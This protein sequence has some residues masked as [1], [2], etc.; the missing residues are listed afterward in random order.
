MQVDKVIGCAEFWE[1]DVSH[2]PV[3]LG[4]S[5]FRTRPISLGF[6]DEVLG[7][8]S[9]SIRPT[10]LCGRCCFP[11]VPRCR[12]LRHLDPVEPVDVVD[13]F[14]C[15]VCFLIPPFHI[16]S[17]RQ[18]HEGVFLKL[19]YPCSEK[20]SLIRKFTV[21]LLEFASQEHHGLCGVL[22]IFHQMA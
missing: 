5:S 12:A 16:L 4:P 2:R 8:F 10:S 19:D 22:I 20:V 6:P 15:L 14:H 13:P 1:A 11:L 18:H 21:G 7:P 17:R 3:D 9:P